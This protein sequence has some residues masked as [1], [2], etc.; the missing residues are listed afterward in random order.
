MKMRMS[1]VVFGVALL[2]PGLTAQAPALTPPQQL[3]HDVYKQLIEINTTDSVGSTTVAAEAMAA[4]FRAAGV[5][6][7]DIFTGGPQPRKGNLVVRIHGRAP[8]LKPL[9]LLAHLDVV[10]ARQED[11]SADLD[12][13]KFIEKDGYYYGRGTADDKAMAAIFVANLLRMKQQGMVPERDIVLALTADEEGG[14][15][16]GAEWLVTNHRALVDAEF[17]LNE[18]GGG[19]A[20]AGRKIVNRVQASEKVYVDFTLEAMNKGGH[21]SQPQAENA[22]YQLAEALAKIGRYAFPVKLNEVTRGYFEKMSGVEK[23]QDAADF[24]AITH[25]TPD[26]AAVARLS[27]VPLYNSMLRT[28]CVATMV[29]AGHAPNALPQRAAANVNCRILPGEDP[30]EVQR[31]LARVIGDPKVSVTAVKPAK[32]SPPSPLTPQIME[33]ITRI[34]EEMWPG[35]AVVPVMSTGATDG[36]YFRQAGVPIYG[37]SGLFGDMDDVRSHGRDERM[38]IKDFYDG[39]EFLWWL[40]NALSGAKR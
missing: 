18:G 40:V 35:V 12:P 15:F 11:W 36:V 10:E 14:D 9:L 3:A 8:A 23:G 37:V 27:A 30:M 5:P 32:P 7:A 28:T 24:K 38:G 19:Q 31:A 17:G 39:Q 33:T 20:K 16:N 26:P 21:S 4:R 1:F 2:A 22:I 25:P 29:T 6:A 34:T 13:F